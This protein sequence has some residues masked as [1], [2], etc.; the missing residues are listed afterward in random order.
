[1]ADEDPASWGDDITQSPEPQIAPPL[2]PPPPSMAP[3][4]PTGAS[5][6]QASTHAPPP[7]AQPSVPADEGVGWSWRSTAVTL[8]VLLVIGAGAFWYLTRDTPVAIEVDGRPITNAETVLERGEAAFTS[9]A[10]TDGATP[11][12]DAGCW[13]APPADEGIA[14]QGPQLACG[15]VL[16]GVSGTTKPWV[17]GRVSYTTSASGDDSTGTFESLDGVGDPDTGDFDRPDGRGVP[18]TSD[19]KPATKGVRAA[20]GRRL[21]GDQAAIDAADD[22]FAEAAADADASVAD[23]SECF[24][25]GTRNRAGQFL[26]E[27]EIW[28]GPVLLLDSDARDS[29][30]MSTFSVGSGDTFALAEAS[31]PSI[32]S[33]TTTVP[34]DPGLDLARPDGH[35]IPDATG[36]KP[37]DAEPVE[38]DAV[39]V[40]D[41]LP[42]EVEFDEPD[43]GRLIIPSRRVQLT[44]LAQVDK[45]GSG[46]GALVAADDHSLV[47]VMLDEEPI[48]DGPSDEGTAQLVV[49][50][51]KSPF[52]EWTSLD[53]S[54]TL[55]LSVP[56][57][58]EEVALEVLFDGV[59]QR[60]SLLTGERA[61]GF[62]AALYREE[63]RAGLGEP[64]N[65]TAALPVGD[66]ASAGGV[67]SEARL[68]AWTDDL[69]WAPDGKAFLVLITDGWETDDPCCEVDDV[70]VMA[71]FALTPDGGKPID[72][73]TSDSSSQPD[74]FF[75][76]PADF[77]TG[78]VELRLRVTFDRD[79]AP[80]TAEGEPV[81]LAIKLP[82]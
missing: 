17:L 34:L 12:A 13:F 68:A 22:A 54:G 41:D 69:G 14:S 16:L 45:V 66:P 48:E 58:V 57:D 2:V 77:A 81:G 62:P 27:G 25:G 75:V 36:L 28:C 8:A 9:L 43:D 15:P 29:W 80:G 60:I 33:L 6:V 10:K 53:G 67:I 50:S 76:V 20:D 55:V 49:D 46:S 7:G 11:A 40:V 19:L 18:S 44:G 4:Q 23:D 32:D 64:L 78:S 42:G 38:D 37:P 24:F 26:T 5:R 3:P 61:G 65:A 59:R 63:T 72:G 47:M 30:S 73:V 79:G 1:M 21:V 31:P 56:D 51:D 39:M 70:E 35:K 52:E 82:A 74:P 71:L